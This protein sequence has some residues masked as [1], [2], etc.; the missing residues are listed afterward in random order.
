MRKRWG[1]MMLFAVASTVSA[2]RLNEQLPLQY[3]Y[4]DAHLSSGSVTGLYAKGESDNVTSVGLGASYKWQETNGLL[5]GDYSARFY[6]PDDDTIERYQLRFGGGYR[7]SLAKQLDLVTH[8]KVGGVRIRVEQGDNE[9]DF[10]YSADIGLRYA[11]T[12]KFEMS[13]TGEAIRNQ[14]QD[15]N[16][17]TLRADYALF[18]RVALGGLIAYRDGE[19]HYINEMALTLRFNY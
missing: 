10:V 15:E 11:V 18:R 1:I 3:D 14:W 2:H 19:G 8:V 17:A 12:P 6:H 16:I 4:L 7:W 5:V 9:T 13:L